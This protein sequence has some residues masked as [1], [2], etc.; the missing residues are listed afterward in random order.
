M[1]VQQ[2]LSTMFQYLTFP[3]FVKN[4]SL[5]PIR[6]S[7]VPA[8]ACCLSTFSCTLPGRVLFCLLYNPSFSC[9]LFFFSRRTETGS[10]SLLVG[11][12]LQHPCCLNDFFLFS[13]SHSDCQW[14]SCAGVPKLDTVLQMQ[15][16][17]GEGSGNFP[18]LAGCTVANVS[19][20]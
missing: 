8:C 2:P 1:G 13:C 3:G 11:C 10:P 15:P 17:S 5:Y 18:C 7:L 19:P 14:L 6:M 16:H 20:V 4:V 9:H 12:V